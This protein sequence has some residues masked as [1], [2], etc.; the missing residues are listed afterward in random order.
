M[1]TLNEQDGVQIA[2]GEIYTDFL[3]VEEN[4]EESVL[5]AHSMLWKLNQTVVTAGRK[6][7]AGNECMVD[8]QAYGKD[9]LGTTIRVS[10][11]NDEDTADMFRYTEYTIVG[12]CNSSYYVNYERGTT[13]LGSGRLK[14]FVYIPKDGFN[15]DY[16]TD[17]YVFLEDRYE[18]Y[19]QEYDDAVDAAV[20]WVEPLAEDLAQERYLTLKEDAQWQ[21]EDGERQLAEN[22]AEAESEFAD[23][24][25]ELEDAEQ[26]IAD[27]Q[28]EIDDGWA[29]IADARQEI[30]DNRATLAESRQELED[31]QTE[32]ADGESELADQRTAAA[33]LDDEDERENMEAGLDLAEAQ[34]RGNEAQLEAGLGLANMGPGTAGG[35]GGA[36]RP[37]RGTAARGGSGSG[38][39]QRRA[40]RR[41][42]RNMR[43]TC[44]ALKNRWQRRK[45]IWRTPGRNSLILRS[46][47]PMSL[48]GMKISV[49]PVT[50]AIPALSKESRAYFRYSFSWWRR[51]SA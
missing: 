17:I 38:R 22:R 5:R 30:E 50:K 34:L 23:A 3:A 40:G 4:G 36:D 43:K 44:R 13:S 31:G 49:M 26:E 20:D 7:T 19:S 28:Q 14:G 33:D 24:R 48:P 46:R 42:G 12:L 45:R 11:N 9:A 10:E 16:Y 51:W 39:C 6:P 18:L 2:E 32:L 15:T 35:R 21:I 37:E 27:G 41:L 29:E 25:Q 1:E 47:I 8:A